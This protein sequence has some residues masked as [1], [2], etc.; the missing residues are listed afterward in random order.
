M[1]S[2]LIPLLDLQMCPTCCGL[3]L[4]EMARPVLAEVAEI[5]KQEHDA[6]IL[7]LLM[8]VNANHIILK[9]CQC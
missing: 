1:W 6:T 5:S 8:E 2:H 4:N 9:F 3:H 7:S